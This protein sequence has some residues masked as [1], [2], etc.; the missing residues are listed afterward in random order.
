EQP[1][2]PIYAWVFVTDRE[3]GLVMVSAGRLVDGD[4]KNNF[5]DKEHIV[6]FNPDGKLAGAMHSYMAGTNLFV[7]GKNG[8]FVLGL[9]NDALEAPT[10]IGELITNTLLTPSLSS[11]DGE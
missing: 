8:L 10:I 3:E 11:S 7:V 9:R 1:V 6:R 2:S 4:P 5:L